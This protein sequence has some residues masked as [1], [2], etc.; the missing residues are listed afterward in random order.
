MPGLND[1]S[2]SFVVRS[3]I[4]NPLGLIGNNNNINIL[5]QQEPLGFDHDATMEVSNH[6][7]STPSRSS[8]ASELDKEI[9]ILDISGLNNKSIP[10]IKKRTSTIRTSTSRARRIRFYR[11]GDKFY[12]GIVIPV[13]NERYRYDLTRWNYSSKNI[14]L[15]HFHFQVIRKP[16][17]RFD[18]LDGRENIR[19]SA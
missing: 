14:I 5:L 9:G 2:S 12:G 13:S 3:N 11:N 1:G 6:S 7:T 18:S 15:E 19:C 16:S 8:S 10:C 17:R 4:A